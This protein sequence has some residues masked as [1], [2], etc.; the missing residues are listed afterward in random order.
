MPVVNQTYATPVRNDSVDTTYTDLVRSVG[1]G[2]TAVIGLYD[3]ETPRAVKRR[4][5]FAAKELG[6]STK[7][8][9]SKNDN[10]IVVS[11][12]ELKESK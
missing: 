6:M 2:K 11:F 5:T 4:I 1:K 7:W 3:D 8:H 10:E 9:T 12:T